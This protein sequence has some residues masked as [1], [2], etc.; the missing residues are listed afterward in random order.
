MDTKPGEAA[1]VEQV[2][3]QAQTEGQ[4]QEQTQKMCLFPIENVQQIVNYLTSDDKYKEINRLLAM[5]QQTEVIDAK[6]VIKK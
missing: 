3:K 1:K 5:V 2:Q 4:A 6:N